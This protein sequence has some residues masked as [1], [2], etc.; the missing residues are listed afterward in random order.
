MI[1]PWSPSL[2]R[3]R[4][5]IRSSSSQSNGIETEARDGYGN[6]RSDLRG[7]HRA[8]VTVRQRDRSARGT[9]P[10]PQIGKAAAAAGV[11][12]PPR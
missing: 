2:L 12:D 7:H 8:G 6:R 1:P 11:P 9:R 10:S 5:G 3:I 4:T